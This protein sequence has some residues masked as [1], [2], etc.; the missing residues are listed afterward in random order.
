MSLFSPTR[1]PT[2]RDTVKLVSKLFG[3]NDVDAVLQRLDRLT[4]DEARTTVAQTLEVIHRLVRNMSIVMDGE[5]LESPYNLRSFK[6]P[7]L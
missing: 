5:Q 2:Q 1:F 4:Q 6:Y 7:S 3:G